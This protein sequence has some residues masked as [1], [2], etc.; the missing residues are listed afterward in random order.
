MNNK[1]VVF[2]DIDGTILPEDTKE[3]PTAN[4]KA[5]NE[6]LINDIEVVITTGRTY[7]SAKKYIDQLNI[8]SYMT[9]DGQQIVL[10]GTNIYS[11]FFD[12]TIRK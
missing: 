6:L 9:S 4:I 11:K 8:D 7:R 5:I 12:D 10:N 2:F 1:K 3:I